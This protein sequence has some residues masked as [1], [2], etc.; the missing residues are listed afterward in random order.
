MGLSGAQ[1][2]PGLESLVL[3]ACASLE[4]LDNQY[5]KHYACSL[6]AISELRLQMRTT[7]LVYIDFLR[8]SLHG[9]KNGRFTWLLCCLH[10]YFSSTVTIVLKFNSLVGSTKPQGLLRMSEYFLW[11]K[12]IYLEKF[13]FRYCFNHIRICF[14][15]R[16]VGFKDCFTKLYSFKVL[17]Q[18]ASSITQT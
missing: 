14:L 10:V 15:C 6:T 17:C 18:V 1:I 7:H 8:I 2:Q 11:I 5:L 9:R 12:N 4:K 3:M 16:M 13:G